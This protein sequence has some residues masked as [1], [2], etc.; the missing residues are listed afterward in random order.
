MLVAINPYARLPLYT[1][2]VM[3]TYNGMTLGELDPH[4]FA[5]ADDALR[6][7]EQNSRNQSIIVRYA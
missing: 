5:V 4:I 1:A 7:L 3:T 6:C 2:D